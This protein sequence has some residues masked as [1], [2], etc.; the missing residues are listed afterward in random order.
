[1]SSEYFEALIRKIKA[2]DETIWDKRADKVKVKT[3]LSNFET[4]NERLT[5]LH[6]LSQFMYFGNTEIRLLLL[7]LYNEHFKYPII[8]KH[9]A[10]LG[11][12]IS[13]QEGEQ[14]FTSVLG[15]TKFLG[16]GNPS[17]SGNHLLYFLR[18]EAGLHKSSFASTDELFTLSRRRKLKLKD[19][20]ITNYIFLDDFCG[21]GEQACRYWNKHFIKALRNLAPKANLYYFV[22]F[23]T[24]SGLEYLRAKTQFTS[25]QS[26]IEFDDSYSIFNSQRYFRGTPPEVTL[27]GAQELALKYGMVL[28]PKHPLGFDEGQMLL[29]FYHNTPDNTLPIIWSPGSHK[30]SWKPM[31]TRYHKA[32]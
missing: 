6:L 8:R 12:M 7:E 5:A 3:W 23:A 13:F 25:I 1:M 20:G 27:K 14:H 10:T 22:L 2:L 24:H 32:E 29:G 17:E 31:F 21:S 15:K 19:P 18:Q 11:R 28:W 16:L 4:D 30:K 26:V 9:R